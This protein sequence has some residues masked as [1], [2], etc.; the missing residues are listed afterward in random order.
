[1][2]Y[3]YGSRILNNA[4]SGLHAQQ[5]VIATTGNNIANVDTEGYTRRVARI[6]NRT[7]E[8][9]ASLRIGNGVEIGEIQRYSD[10]YIEGKLRDALAFKEK[11]ATEDE[12]V[13]RIESLFDLT[14]ESQTIGSSLT[15]FYSAIDDL[16]VN[17]SNIELRTNLLESAKTLISSIKSTYEAVAALQ[18]EAD[19][20]IAN[21]LNTVNAL[22]RSIANLNLR[23]SSIERSGINH[24]FDERDERDKLLLDLSEKIDYD[25]IENSDGSVTVSLSNGFYLVHSGN[26]HELSVDKTPSFL[27][28]NLPAESLS[29]GNLSYITYD[30]S[31]GAGTG[32]INLTNIIARGGGSIAGLLNVRGVQSP[33]DD[34][35]FDANGHLVDIAQ[36]IEGVTRNLLTRF[37]EVY[38]GPDPQ[39]GLFSGDL[40]GNNPAT[41][42]FFT[43]AGATDFDGD[44]I[45]TNADLDATLTNIHSYSRYLELGVKNA[46]NIAAAYPSEVSLGVYE[47]APGDS[48]NL[49]AISDL[50][51][52]KTMVFNVP[53]GN[54]TYSFM[55]T[56]EESYHEMVNF[57]GNLRSRTMVNKS[58]S[59]DKYISTLNE[60]DQVS[61][62]SLDEEYTRLI[63]AQQSYQASARMIRIAQELFDEII[64]M[65]S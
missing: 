63:T 37:N 35:P 25:L 19:V 56:F 29:G 38:L 6:T 52:D 27:K 30:Y 50:K 47:Y 39:N 48:R 40:D 2:A 41:F 1:M 43:F 15:A 55:G 65:Y 46:R 31:Y 22:T 24:A 58:V 36:R 7:E 18:D 23:I 8:N 44:N 45:P 61:A 53:Q 21:E 28:G 26:Y 49:S 17:P 34:S 33:T 5:G 12:F 9:S 20:R 11:G 42:G 13:S 54:G 62:V 10:A 14:G 64:A 57:V 59:E 16:S 51:N 32:D 3:N 60:H 4:V